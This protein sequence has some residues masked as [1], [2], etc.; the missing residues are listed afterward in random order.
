MGTQTLRMSSEEFWSLTYEEF[1]AR[2]DRHFEEQ[3]RWDLRFG[4]GPSVYVNAHLKEGADPVNPGDF[5][6]YTTE[7]EPD[8]EMTPEESLAHVKAMFQ[9][10]R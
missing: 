10:K 5:F 9:A 6:G 7:S 4:V 3:K 1:Y 2:E 8:R